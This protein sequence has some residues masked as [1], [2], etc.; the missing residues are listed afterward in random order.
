MDILALVEAYSAH[1]PGSRL[2]YSKDSAGIMI[3]ISGS[4]ELKAADELQ[5]LLSHVIEDLEVGKRLAI[6]LAGVDYISSTGIGA[7]ATALISAR[8]RNVGIVFRRVSPH[9]A[10]IFDVLGL[11]RYFPIEDDG[12]GER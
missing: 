5:N 9:V 3:G 8:R 11:M 12:R 6:D 1:N 4:L 10:S 2:S 7:L